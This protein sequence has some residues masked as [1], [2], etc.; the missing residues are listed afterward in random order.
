MALRVHDLDVHL[1]ANQILHGISLSIGA[2]E[3]V[4]L[5]GGN[6]SGKTTAVRAIVGAIP[7]SRGSIE[8]FGT[9]AD[10]AAHARL[11]YVPQRLTA[12]SG[13]QASALE[14]VTSGL[15]T[16]YQM[17]PGKSAKSRAREAL[18]DVGLEDVAHQAVSTLSGG[19]Q[20]RV[21]IARA[22]VREPELLILDEPLAGVDIPSQEVFAEALNRAK[23]NGA[24]ILIV[25][26]ETGLIGPLLDR[27]VVLERGCVTYEGA[28][29]E[30]TGAHALPGHDHVH[31][32]G[33]DPHSGTPLA[34]GLN[35]ARKTLP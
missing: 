12:S 27:A 22:L 8:I 29:P 30:A 21:L 34:S 32:H 18:A 20:Q 28:P 4:A 9:P 25:L 13:V 35:V 11:G 16:G 6:A 17:W 3:A 5:M 19:Q 26:H 23:D 24:S 1:S 33:R 10:R 7:F 2:G 14:L 15:L 31:P